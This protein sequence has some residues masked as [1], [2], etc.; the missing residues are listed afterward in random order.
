MEGNEYWRG[1][2]G[3]PHNTLRMLS[4]PPKGTRYA[5]IAGINFPDVTKEEV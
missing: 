3:Y 1:L 5:T 4:G 2:W